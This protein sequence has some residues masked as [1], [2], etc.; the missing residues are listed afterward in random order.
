MGSIECWG[1]SIRIRNRN[2]RKNRRHRA[3]LKTCFSDRETNTFSVTKF[4]TFTSLIL[5]ILTCFVDL[6]MEGQ[7]IGPLDV[8][9]VYNVSRNRSLS[10]L[11]FITFKLQIE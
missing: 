6:R 10:F 7:N 8:W 2:R 4:I 11:K 1:V 9:W 3:P 5:G